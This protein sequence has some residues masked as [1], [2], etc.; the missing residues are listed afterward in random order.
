MTFKNKVINLI[1]DRISEANKEIR[2]LEDQS[3]KYSVAP[4]SN[5]VYTGMVGYRE[6]LQ[7]LLSEI[8]SINENERNNRDI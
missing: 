5:G 3:K 2:H 8:R 7:D 1:L 6:A 4:G